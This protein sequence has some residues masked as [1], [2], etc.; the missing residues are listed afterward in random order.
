MKAV[1]DRC[2]EKLVR[3]RMSWFNTDIIC[4]SCQRRE[5]QHPDI[6]YARD[7]ETAAV[8]AGD[9]NFPGVGW[10]GVDGRVKREPPS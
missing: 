8:L 7:K 5:N 10:P 4:E 3:S 6:R 2:E 9:T 1:C